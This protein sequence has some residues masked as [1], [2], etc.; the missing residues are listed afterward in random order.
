MTKRTLL[1]PIKLIPKL[2]KIDEHDAIDYTLGHIHYD[3]SL[4][5]DYDYRIIRQ[6]THDGTH[7]F[8][9][10]LIGEALEP[11]VKKGTY[12]RNDLTEDQ[13]KSLVDIEYTIGNIELETVYGT[14]QKLDG[15]ILGVTDI[16]TIPVR[17]HYV[18]E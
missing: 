5:D 10:M 1:N 17:C 8:T 16:V 9:L 2:F 4:D 15:E 3:E 13:A 12:C 6:S 11:L 14:M 7:L 18:F